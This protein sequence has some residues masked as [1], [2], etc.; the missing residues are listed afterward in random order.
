MPS[1][2]Q[3][4]QL[5]FVT[6]TPFVAVDLAL[7][8]WGLSAPEIYEFD[9]ERGLIV[10]E[11]FGDRVFTAELASGRPL[12]ELTPAAVDVLLAIAERPA[13]QTLPIEGHAPYR[14]Q[15]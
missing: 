6:V 1:L 8:A 2:R 14:L 15:T 5:F 10:L 9:L 13:P 12:S 7:R 3:L 4:P 11:D